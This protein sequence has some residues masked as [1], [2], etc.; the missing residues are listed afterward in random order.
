L[1][2]RT[3]GSHTT[4]TSP[5]TIG[6]GGFIPVPP[7]VP[8]GVPGLRGPG[9]GPIN[10]PGNE[11]D[12][13]GS[14]NIKSKAK[15][16]SLQAPSMTTLSTRT[17]S[18]SSSTTSC[19]SCDSC[20]DLHYAPSTTPDEL[21]KRERGGQIGGRFHL[22][23]RG[24]QSVTRTV[25]AGGRCTMSKYTYKPPYPGPASVAN[26]E[27]PSP[28]PSMSKFYQTAAFWAI[29]TQVPCNGAPAWAF[30]DTQQLAAQPQPYRLGGDS[31]TRVNVS[32]I[33]VRL[34][35]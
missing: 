7:V 27:G 4:V 2:T 3:D 11:P 12:Q 6:P 9:P 1:A 29:P 34:V 22:D 23:K 21:G 13:P 19:S 30:V 20:V 26:N 32:P 16:S 18:T 14:S 33:S 15:E 8:A 35:V 5:V 31:G 24:R 10:G 25:V 28:I 17:S